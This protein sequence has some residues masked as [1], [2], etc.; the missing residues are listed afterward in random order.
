MALRPI[1]HP[2]PAQS[3]KIIDHGQHRYALHYIGT[4]AERID[5]KA[6]KV[7]T[8]VELAIDFS[9]SNKPDKAVKQAIT[10][11]WMIT[12]GRQDRLEEVLSAYHLDECLN[13]G[14]GIQQYSERYAQLD[15]DLHLAS[16]LIS[17]ARIKQE[18]ASTGVSYRFITALSKDISP[19]MTRIIADA[20]KCGRTQYGPQLFRDLLC[21][22]GNTF[23]SQVQ[24]ICKCY[25][26]QSEYDRALQEANISEL[27]Q[28]CLSSKATTISPQITHAPVPKSQEDS[29][30][31]K[32][33][34][35][36]FLCPITREVMEDP[37]LTLKCQTYER[38]AIEEWL[39][40]H[41]TDPYTNDPLPDKTLIPNFALKSAIQEWKDTNSTYKNTT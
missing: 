15:S 23:M 11:L 4:V 34:F 31:K 16:S 39:E 12:G 27:G 20:E 21:K 35:K 17:S 38:D 14:D 24:R 22:F 41:D 18:A 9:F 7:M 19:E 33:P 13:F 37:V 32:E 5:Q 28:R 30:V 1:S 36:S 10:V 6:L 2:N 29:K 26:L 40:N 3:D 25:G 8:E